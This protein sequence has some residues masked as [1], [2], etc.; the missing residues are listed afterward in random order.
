[1]KYL[2]NNCTIRKLEP[3]DEPAVKEICRK[4]FGPIYRYFAIQSLSS[5]GQ[6]LVCVKEN[7]IAG[8][9]KL[10]RNQI[11]NRIAGDILWL[12]VRPQFRKAG[13][14]SNLITAG[15]NDFRKNGIRHIYVSAGRNNKA[16]IALFEKNG[17]AKTGF[18]N[19][20]K[21]YGVQVFTFYSE[22]WISPTEVVLEL[23]EPTTFS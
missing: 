22:L 1:V 14:A 21:R 12:A 3:R 2:S 18:F 10:T 4:S 16:A 5:P 11:G 19:L 8:F 13:V 23:E 6:V 9:V 17:F 20:I 15:I 7:M